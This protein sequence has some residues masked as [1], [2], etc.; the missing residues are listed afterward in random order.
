MAR[1]QQSP[2]SGWQP[3][4]PGGQAPVPGAPFPSAGYAPAPARRPRRRKLM[5]A[6]AVAA[7]VVIAGLIAGI[8][9]GAKPKGSVAL[10]GTLLSLPRATSP[11]AEHLARTLRTQEEAGT[12]GRLNG[13]V[14]GVYGDPA[15]AWLAISGG[16]ICGTCSAKSP[17]AV[18]RNLTAHDYAHATG[19]PA[20]PKGG[21]LACGAR[22]VQG[23][24]LI[25]CTWVDGGTA[26]DVLFSPGVATSL[27]DAAAKT[28][29]IRVAT[30]H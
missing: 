25:R 20:G 24:T 3:V 12:S 11:S 30:E 29:Q 7:V 27:A 26:G 4:L 23:S 15:G 9:L 21:V 1:K 14:A 2:V 28:N 17:A 6:T 13:V 16:G 10:P 18:R 19:Y 8:A 5:L 22:V